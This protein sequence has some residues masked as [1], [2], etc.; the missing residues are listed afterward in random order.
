[1]LVDYYILLF[2]RMC[3][4]RNGLR[5]STSLAPS[6]GFGTGVKKYVCVADILL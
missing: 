3:Y 6:F 4:I 2:T 1:M 5:G